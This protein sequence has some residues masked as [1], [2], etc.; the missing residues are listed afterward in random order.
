MASSTFCSLLQI[1]FVHNAD[2]HS[3]GQFNCYR[4]GANASRK[5]IQIFLDHYCA[6]DFPVTPFLLCALQ[7]W[8]ILVLADSCCSSIPSHQLGCLYC[9]LQ[10]NSLISHF[11]SPRPNSLPL[12]IHSCTTAD[13]IW[14]EHSTPKKQSTANQRHLL[15]AIFQP[16]NTVITFR[17]KSTSVTP[18]GIRL[19]SWARH[20]AEQTSYINGISQTSRQWLHHAS[21]GCHLPIASGRGPTEL[22]EIT[23][24]TMCI[25]TSEWPQVGTEGCS[26]QAKSC[27]DSLQTLETD[28]CM[29]YLTETKETFSAP[30]SATNRTVPLDE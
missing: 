28:F 13:R 29:N 12:L 1:L 22:W 19:S 5:T 9:F 30:T 3:G 25:F 20:L 2:A 6:L 23:K 15:P 17:D 8:F 14:R 24:V 26:E 21:S 27:N 10:R 18:S 11:L 16:T 7:L 4:T